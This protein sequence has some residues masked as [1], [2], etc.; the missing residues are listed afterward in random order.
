MST[1]DE[2]APLT[3]AQNWYPFKRNVS[4]GRK[5]HRRF[6]T[7]RGSAMP[8]RPSRPLR[9]VSVRWQGDS[10][11]D[12]TGTPTLCLQSLILFQRLA[13]MI[14]VQANWFVALR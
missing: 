14:E 7:I 10:A 11:C 12:G 1:E 2:K 4:G 5:W 8:H 9:G 13:Q 3:N 6:L